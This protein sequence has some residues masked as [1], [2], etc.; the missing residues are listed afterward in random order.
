M[1]PLLSAIYRVRKSV[2]DPNPVTPAALPFASAMFFIRLHLPKNDLDLS[3]NL[4]E[5]C[6]GL[7]FLA[8]ALQVDRMVVGAGHGLH[9]SC[10]ELVLSVDAGWLRVGVLE[11]SASSLK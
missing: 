10:K 1:T 6:D 8:L 4:K 2:D 9:C 5:G 7:S 11:S 3:G